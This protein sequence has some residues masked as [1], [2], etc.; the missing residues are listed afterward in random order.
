[1]KR[2]TP[3]IMVEDVNKSIDYYKQNLEFEFVMGVAGE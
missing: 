2:I 3:N 1:M